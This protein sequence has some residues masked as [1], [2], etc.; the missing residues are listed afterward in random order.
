MATGKRPAARKGRSS[1]LKLT[2][3]WAVVLGITGCSEDLNVPAP[4]AE[5]RT[6]TVPILQA[7]FTSQGIC[8]GWRLVDGY[9]VVSVGSNQGD[10]T[11]VEDAPGCPRWIE[12]YADIT[13]TA[14]SSEAEDSATIEVKGSDDLDL[15]GLYAIERGLGQFGLDDA[16]FIDDPGWAITRA[17]T[18]LPLLAAEAGIA[19]SAATPTAAPVAA[20]S[21]LPDA[22]NDFWRDRWGF[23]LGAVGLLLLAAL[24]VTVGVVQRRKLRAPGP[25]QRAGAGAAGRT[26]GKA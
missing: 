13:Y 17:A 6:D 5:E 22:G 16:T 21:P 11:A 24:L 12:V 1:I 19:K 26:R 7:A 20:P 4:A 15:A 2:L 18:T 23:L 25:A 3:I 8:Y 10:G 14:E 9:D